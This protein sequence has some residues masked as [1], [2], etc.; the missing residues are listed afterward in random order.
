MSKRMTMLRNCVII[1][2]QELC[3]EYVMKVLWRVAQTVHMY[4]MNYAKL[5]KSC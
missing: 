5:P 4:Q 3:V 1:V 2:G